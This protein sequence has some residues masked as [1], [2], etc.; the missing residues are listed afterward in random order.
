MTDFD[1]YEVVVQKSLAIKV[2]PSENLEDGWVTIFTW[3]PGDLPPEPSVLEIEIAAKLAKPRPTDIV[4]NWVRAG[5]DGVTK[6]KTLAVGT[7]ESWAEVATYLERLTNDDLPMS[8]QLWCK[9]NSM[10][11]VKV[12]PKAL[13]PLSLIRYRL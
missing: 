12:I 4:S 3:E 13:S 9:G 6:R 1:G 5:V 10:T 7:I 11:V 2:N 8:Y